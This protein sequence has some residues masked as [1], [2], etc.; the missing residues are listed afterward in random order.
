MNRMTASLLA[1]NYLRFDSLALGT[2][3]RK[4]EE[5]PYSEHCVTSE[6]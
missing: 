5:F 1:D 3:G 4:E 2:I 6:G